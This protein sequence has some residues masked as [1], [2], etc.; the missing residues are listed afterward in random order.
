MCANTDVEEW[1]TWH[2]EEQTAGSHYPAQPSDSGASITASH[3]M[4][5]VK[6]T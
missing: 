3:S 4:S 5:S 6:L 2:E 1:L